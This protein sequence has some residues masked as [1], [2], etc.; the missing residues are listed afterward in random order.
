[1]WD[2]KFVLTNLAKKVLQCLKLL[3]QDW[4]YQLKIEGRKNL[5]IEI[6]FAII[7]NMQI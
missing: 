1:M 4:H 5:A 7:I 2:A 3:Y 6:L